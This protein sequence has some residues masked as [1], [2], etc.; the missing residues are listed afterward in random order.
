MVGTVRI[1]C[2]A[3]SLSYT[4]LDI[5][6]PRN[7]RQQGTE[8]QSLAG[9]RKSEKFA[10]KKCI[11]R[12]QQQEILIPSPFTKPFIPFHFARSTC[13][14]IYGVAQHQLTEDSPTPS[15]GI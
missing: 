9:K 8:S 3:P 11:R 6:P 1:N 5:P 14:L 2:G 7:Q 15:P 10:L 4:L 12:E 13:S